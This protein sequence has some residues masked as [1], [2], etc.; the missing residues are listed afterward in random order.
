MRIKFQ[1][2]NYS[3]SGLVSFASW[4]NHDLQE[5]IRRAFNESPREEIVELVIDRDGIK[6]VFG[7]KS[8]CIK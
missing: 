6:A 2:P 1:P 5:A 8:G 4:E 3:P 7:T